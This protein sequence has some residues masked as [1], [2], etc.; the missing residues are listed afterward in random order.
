MILSVNEIKNKISPILASYGARSASLFGSYARGEATEESDVDLYV[1]G[2]DSKK[3]KSLISFS[4]LRLDMI[5]ALGKE[6]DLLTYISDD[7]IDSIFR[8]NFY[9]DEVKI[10]E[11]D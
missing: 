11:A 5:D 10:Y 1:D 8:N 9:R 7:E 3:L 4:G 2:G 6:V